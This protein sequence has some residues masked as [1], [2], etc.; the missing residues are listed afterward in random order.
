MGNGV[1]VEYP[2]DVTACAWDSQNASIA[3]REGRVGQ[4][5]GKTSP[6]MLGERITAYV[7]GIENASI[8]GRYSRL[9]TGARRVAQWGNGVGH[10][11]LLSACP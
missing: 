9:G 7:W 6:H 1:G 10:P 2:L 5:E 4:G 3:G 8:A 11:S